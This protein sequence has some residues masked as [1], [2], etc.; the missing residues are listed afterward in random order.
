LAR[1]IVTLQDIS[2]YL[3]PK[4][5]KLDERSVYEVGV[6]FIIVDPRIVIRFH[7]KPHFLRVV[8]FI[9]DFQCERVAVKGGGRE[10]VGLIPTLVPLPNLKLA[11]Q[12]P[13]PWGEF[14]MVR[15]DAIPNRIMDHVGPIIIDAKS[16]IRI[17]GLRP[18]SYPGQGEG[19]DQSNSF[20]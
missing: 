3:L 18:G 8:F 1:S 17:A 20:D 14:G 9:G 15:D 6:T 5:V 12:L 10:V 13:S 7:L 11:G 4:D 19:Q 16:A 2:F